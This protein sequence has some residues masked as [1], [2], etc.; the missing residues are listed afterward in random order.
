MNNASYEGCG[1]LIAP[2]RPKDRDMADHA[3]LL[4]GSTPGRLDQFE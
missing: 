1:K 3:A 4:T 2:A